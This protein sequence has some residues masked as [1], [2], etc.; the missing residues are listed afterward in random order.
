MPKKIPFR[1]GALVKAKFTKARGRVVATNPFVVK[2][3]SNNKT[4]VR[5][6]NPKFWKKR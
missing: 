6:S 3:K 2:F 5:I 1:K 4:K